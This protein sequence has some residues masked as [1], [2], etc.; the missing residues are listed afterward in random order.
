MS[1]MGFIMMNWSSE[2]MT[3]VKRKRRQNDELEDIDSKER[4]RF[5]TS[6]GQMKC[7]ECNQHEGEFD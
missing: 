2:L 3:Q 5:Q 1:S 6:G 7:N 4:K